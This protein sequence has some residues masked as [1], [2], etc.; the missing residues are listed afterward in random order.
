MMAQHEV[1]LNDD[2]YEAL[3]EERF[4]KTKGPG[5]YCRDRKPCEHECGLECWRNHHGDL[6]RPEDVQ[7]A[8]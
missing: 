4:M 3:L 6:R 1:V 5:R 7:D 8:G 2:E